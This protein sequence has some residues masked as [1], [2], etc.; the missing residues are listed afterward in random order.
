MSEDGE[1]QAAG[2]QQVCFFT[3]FVKENFK[4]KK[5]EIHN[6]AG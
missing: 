1:L 6:T 2:Y 3:Q 5:N 4:N